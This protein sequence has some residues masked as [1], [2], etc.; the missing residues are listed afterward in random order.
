MKK[1]FFFL[2]CAL[3]LQNPQAQ[4]SVSFISPARLY[5]EGKTLYENQMY[6]ACIEKLLEYK[7]AAQNPELIQEADFLLAASGFYRKNENARL[8]L[9]AYLD[10]YPV[11]RHQDET[12]FMIAS[13][14]FSEKDYQESIFW[15]AQVE[16]NNLSDEQQED[17]AYQLGYSYLENGN[18]AEA[19]RLFSLL[20]ANSS[21]YRT[22]ATFYLAYIF[23][24]ENDYNQAL[25]LFNQ[26]KNQEKFNPDVL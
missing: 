5:Q 25:A 9:T 24:A 21:Q 6:A 18:K 11:N 22:T 7:K 23:Y 17:Y 15:F 12:C 2:C 16:L 8:E 20:K 1:T 14:Y 3:C 19:K 13:A 4:R 26:L 10:K